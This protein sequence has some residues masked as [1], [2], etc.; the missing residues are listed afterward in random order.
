MKYIKLFENIQGDIRSEKINIINSGGEQTEDNIYELLKKDCQPFLKELTNQK[1]KNFLYR[2]IDQSDDLIR[3]KKTRK[4]RLPKDTPDVTNYLMNDIWK[5]LH[6]E[7]PRKEGVFVTNDPNYLGEDEGGKMTIFFPIGNYKYFYHPDIDDLYPFIAGG[8][9]YD[10]GDDIDYSK[11]MDE[12]LSKHNLSITKQDIAD[13]NKVNRVLSG[14]D[15]PYEE[16]LD[17]IHD[18]LGEDPSEEILEEWAE[19]VLREL[20]EQLISE[21][22]SDNI[23]H[24]HSKIEAT[25][26]CDSYY[27]INI[28]DVDQFKLDDLIFGK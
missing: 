12:Y 13:A 23:F 18:K 16:L 3:Y 27:L 2:F 7:I 22:K 19:S 24:C 11:K 8:G 14:S 10:V 5:E 17:R 4:D 26:L 6:G 9:Q 1:Y 28:Y 20:M 25:F 15:M 21:Y